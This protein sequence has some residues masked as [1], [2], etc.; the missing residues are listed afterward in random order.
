MKTSHFDGDYTKWSFYS[1]GERLHRDK[2][3]PRRRPARHSQMFF[4]A[5]NYDKPSRIVPL[6]G[7]PQ[8]ERGG[9]T[10]R[11]ILACLQSYLPGLVEEGETF[12][13]DNAR[14]FKAKIVQ[15]WLLPWARRHGVSL[16]DWPPYSPDLNPIE[17]L[18][19]VL[20]KRICETY[21]EI[22]AYPKSAAAMARL[23]EAAEELWSEVEDEVVKNVIKSMPDRLNACWNA[24]G[25]YTKY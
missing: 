24:N 13:H 10:G 12:Q 25:Y 20:K 1:A 3:Q 8:S 6:E 14:T 5:I 18:W 19:K 7:D 21:P 4:G 16:T 15:E 23:I 2:V 17:N 22:A 11:R 9:V